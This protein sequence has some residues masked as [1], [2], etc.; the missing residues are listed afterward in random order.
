MA[1]MG[2]WSERDKVR[3]AT[4]RLEDAARTYVQAAAELRGKEVK[5]ADFKKALQHRF[6]DPRTDN[7]HYSQLHA[8]KQKPNE[9]V[10]AFADRVRLY[11]RAIT[12]TENTPEAERECAAQVAKMVLAAF[13]NGL[14]GKPGDQTRFTGPASLEEA[15]QIAVTVEQALAC[16]TKNDAF[17]LNKGEKE[18]KPPSK[19][20]GEGAEGK[21]DS[22]RRRSSPSRRNRRPP[23]SAQRPVSKPTGDTRCYS[24]SGFGHFASVCP[25]RL[26]GIE[27]RGQTGRRRQFNDSKARERQPDKRNFQSGENKVQPSGNC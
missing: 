13:K 26:E 23:N 25:T 20:K 24:C 3:I 4:L 12:P 10:L 6:R 5:W 21:L 8:A 9:S 27:V 16:Q 14:A 22:S 1:D 17:F 18:E 7:F 2:N 11:G 19:G 15:I